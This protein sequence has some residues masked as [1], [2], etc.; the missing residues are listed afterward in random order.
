MLTP[1]VLD[2]LAEHRAGQR[3][4]D[5]AHRRHRR[6]R[7]GARPAYAYIYRGRRNDAGRPLGYVKATVEAALRHPEIGDEFAKFLSD[8]T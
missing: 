6:G 4:R 7:A 5:P 2:A 3:R 1:D 8:L